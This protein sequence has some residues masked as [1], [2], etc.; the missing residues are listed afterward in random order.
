M[1][2]AY[3]IA[4]CDDKTNALK[5]VEVWSSPEWQQSRCIPNCRTY[6]AYTV[7]ATTFS[8][9][10]RLLLQSIKDERSRYHYLSHFFEENNE[11]DNRSAR[12]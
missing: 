12:S 5:D 8:E 2:T 6:V 9:A 10:K 11:E 3:L 4:I 7:S 1:N